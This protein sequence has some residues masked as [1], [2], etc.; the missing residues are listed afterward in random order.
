MSP[1]NS[2]VKCDICD[3]SIYDGQSLETHKLIH[4]GEKSFECS[5]CGKRFLRRGNLT[6]H[7]RLVHS[8]YSKSKCKDRNG[9][10]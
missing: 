3:V 6:D 2:T 5:S 10:G 7:V 1:E 4:F 9:S 8:G